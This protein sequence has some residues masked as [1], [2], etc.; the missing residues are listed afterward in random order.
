MRVPDWCWDDLSANLRAS[1]SAAVREG[2]GSRRRRTFGS[3]R[4]PFRFRVDL[5]KASS[6]R[7]EVESR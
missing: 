1:L 5:D 2:S 3:V 4:V 6:F 7:F